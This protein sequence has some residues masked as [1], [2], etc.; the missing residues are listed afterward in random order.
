LKNFFPE[1]KYIFKNFSLIIIS[2]S[3]IW[4]ISTVISQKAVEYSVLEFNKLPSEAAFLLLYS[5]V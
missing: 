2:S 4:V 1:L 3:F 5:S